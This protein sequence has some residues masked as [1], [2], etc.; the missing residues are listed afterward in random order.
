M[1]KKNYV[2]DIVAG[3]TTELERQSYAPETIR[4]FRLDCRKFHDYVL[5]T[6]GEGFFSEDVARKYLAEKFGY[7]EEN[8]E[9]LPSSTVSAIKCI[10]WI[11]EYDLYGSFTRLNKS[12]QAPVSV[13][14]LGDEAAITEYLDSIQT[15][16]N[17]ESTREL[18]MTA[19]RTF[20]DFLGNHRVCGIK[21]MSS[22]VIADYVLS[23]SCF[24][25]GTIKRRLS[26]LRNYFRFLHK[27]GY[28]EKDWSFVV[29]T[30]KNPQN[31]NLPALWTEGEVKAILKNIDR[32]SPS[33]KRDY[34]ILLLVVQL[35]LRISD[36]SNLRLDSLDFDGRKIELIQQ[37][38]GNELILPL[39]GDLGWAIIDYIKYARPKSDDPFVFL[40]QNAPYRKMAPHTVGDVIRTAMKG[41]G[42]ERRPN[43]VSGMHSLRHALARR[44]LKEGIELSDIANIMGHVDYSSTSTYLRTDID[45]LRD[46]CLS[47]NGGAI[48]A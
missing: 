22:T 12:T 46:C 21:A 27:N 47:V 28:C 15:A 34:A 1:E 19:I 5:E 6:D 43:I 2:A 42:I 3:I 4:I 13:W 7:A 29:P 23:L 38:T 48:N 40:C 30:V 36:V 35:G 31:M 20:Y 44:L 37:K 25:P 45:G 26:L 14:S 10:R 16:D 32:G 8:T 9:K 33:G 41:L 24:A 18:R 39:P 17:T 11:S